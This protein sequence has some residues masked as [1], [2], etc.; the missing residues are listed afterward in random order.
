MAR[1]KN[2]QGT[3]SKNL[4]NPSNLGS[5]IPPIFEKP[6]FSLQS[7]SNNNDYSFKKCSDKEKLAL[8]TRLVELS[9]HTWAT[10]HSE[11]RHGIGSEKITISKEK[12][13]PNT[14]NDRQ[15]YALRFDT[16]NKAFVGY[17]CD[18]G[19]FHIN[20]IDRKYKLYSH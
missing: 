20:W 16:G 9:Q 6:I 13:P 12:K 3:G 7:I 5:K 15:Y 17:K 10:I 14:P 1:L 2:K 8:I 19:V 11:N 4:A 18:N